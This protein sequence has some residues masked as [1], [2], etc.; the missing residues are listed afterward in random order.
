MLP[1]RICAGLIA[2]ACLGLGADAPGPDPAPRP[3]ALHEDFEGPRTAW[4]RE[5]SDTTITLHAHERSDRAAH[6]GRRSERFR[7]DAGPGS[8]LYF[9]YSLPRVP[10]DADPT[11]RL[12]VRGDREGVQLFGR[13]VLPADTDPD[14]G[15]PS[16]VLVPGA[17]YD[18]PGHWQLLELAEVRTLAERQARVLRASGKR[19]VSLDGAYL[20]RLVVNVMGAPGE[21]DVFLDDLTVG[22]I[23][24]GSLPTLPPPPVA[25]ADAGPAGGG[26]EGE[27]EGEG[28]AATINSGGTG[29]VPAPAP[30]GLAPVKLEQNRL[31]LEGRPWFLSIVS[32]PGADPA[33]LRKAA[34]RVMAIPAGAD[35]EVARRAARAGMLLMPG[36]DLTADGVRRDPEEVLADAARFPEL[37]SVAFWDFGRRLGARA[38]REARKAD[39]EHLR[40]VKLRLIRGAEGV[41]KLATG[42][43]DGDFFALANKV[44]GGLDLIGVHPPNWGSNVEMAEYQAYLSQR[45]NLTAGPS[46]EAT[47]WAMIDAA[48]PPEVRGAAWGGHTPP[49]WARA[50]VQPEQVRLFVYAALSAGYRGIG[51]RGDAELTRPAGRPLL[52]ELAFLNA[53]IALVESI[54]AQGK[55]PIL[56][57][58]TY[59]PDP[60]K[61]IPLN[62]GASSAGRA[63]RGGAGGATSPLAPPEMPPQPTIRAAS[64][65]TLDKRGQL[66]LVADYALGAQWQPPQMATRNLKIRIPGNESATAWEIGLGGVKYLDSVLVAGGKEITVEEFGTT[67]MILLTYDLAQKDRIEAAVNAVRSKAILMALDQARAEY[68]AVEEVH[69]RLVDDGHDPKDSNGP[70]LLKAA[71][72]SIKSADEALQREDYPL[73]WAEARRASRP[74]RI[75]E[76]LHFD[77][78]LFNFTDITGITHGERPKPKP[79]IWVN[80]YKPPPKPPKGPFPPT[81]VTAAS[82]PP[83][84]AFATL[85]RQYLWNDWIKEKRFGPNKV[86]GGDF[87]ATNLFASLKQNGWNRDD[88]PAEGVVSDLIAFPGGYGAS[89]RMLWFK[90]RAAKPDLIDTLAPFLD[91]PPVT[92]VSPPVQVYHDEIVRISVNVQMPTATTPGVGGVIVRDT[93]GGEALQFRTGGPIPDWR[94]VV[95]YRQ[96]PADGTMTV[97]LGLAGFG[98]AFFDDLRVE[99]L[100]EPARDEA[101]GP[102]FADR[103]RRRAAIPDGPSAPDLAGRNRRRAEAS[104][105]RPSATLPAPAGRT[106]R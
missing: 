12:Y 102:E 21:S 57:V 105:P 34:F 33:V 88:Y 74:L 43:V 81:L 18:A 101:E 66:L 13:V 68:A 77:D 64:I 49:A 8:A 83:M 99:R 54:L 59:P 41:P 67:A 26:G 38:D 58:P 25:G 10:I 56:T 27:G 35:P 19:K 24:A 72:D 22:P 50:R 31:K 78:A 87:E 69:R 80:P 86:R 53:E 1:P 48:P 11:A 30:A 47:Y 51:I 55:D 32:A 5:E 36:L 28:G 45:R 60:P 62:S 94:R 63:G 16:F 100:G 89:K 15:Q 23:P 14:T 91:H 20:E 42:E 7:F 46:P 103:G 90:V 98:D 6:D 75:L 37:P 9:S 44:K 29:G 104:P 84:V 79:W 95:L 17:R 73:A 106:T 70:E 96:V 92:L 65:A 93:I 40:E 3:D 52:N 4:R 61:I 39:L 97:T 2:A 82:S 71:R 85:P 76:R